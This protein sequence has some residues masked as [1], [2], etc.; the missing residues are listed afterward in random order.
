[1]KQIGYDVLLLITIFLNLAMPATLGLVTGV[2]STVVREQGYDLVPP[3]TQ[4]S[5]EASALNFT[6]AFPVPK[7]GPVV[8]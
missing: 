7:P 5:S 3:L 2:A 8:G 6:I 4:F 1:M